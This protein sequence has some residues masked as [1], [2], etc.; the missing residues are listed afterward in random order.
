MNLLRTAALLGAGY[1]LY[2][3]LNPS[4]RRGAALTQPMGDPHAS[5]S[6]G[7]AAPEASARMQDSDRFATAPSQSTEG[8]APGRGASRM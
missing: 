8:D 1:M 5:T 7:T 2:K 3:T 4:G 6:S